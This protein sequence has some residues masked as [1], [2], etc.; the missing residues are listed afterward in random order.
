MRDP[1]PASVPPPDTAI[2]DDAP[3]RGVPVTPFAVATEEAVPATL[4]PPAA[5]LVHR[6]F[7]AYRARHPATPPGVLYADVSL[8]CY[9]GVVVHPPQALYTEGHPPPMGRT[10]PGG[11]P[12]VIPPAQQ[13]AAERAARAPRDADAHEAGTPPAGPLVPPSR[14]AVRPYAPADTRPLS[15]DGRAALVDAP[16]RGR[17]LPVIGFAGTRGSGKDAAALGCLGAPR[18]GGAR[19]LPPGWVP[20]ALADDLKRRVA[21]AFGVPWPNLTGPSRTREQPVPV[22]PDWRERWGV[23]FG[24]ALFAP[25]WSPGGAPYA[26]GSDLLRA[27]DVARANVW[28]CIEAELAA[29]DSGPGGTITARFLLQRVGTDFARRVHDGV[30]VDRLWATYAALCG[31]AGYRRTAGVIDAGPCYW[32][33]EAPVPPRP[34]TFLPLPHDGETALSLGGSPGSVCGSASPLPVGVL[35]TDARFPNE[36]RAVTRHGPPWVQPGSWRHGAVWWLDAEGAP[37]CPPRMDHA[38]E[39]EYGDLVHLV[40]GVIPNR[41]EDGDL[42]AFTRRVLGHVHGFLDTLPG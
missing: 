11:A 18:D 31:G 37:W 13:R 23:V 17:L 16:A 21:F 29:E 30:W 26:P 32:P 42:A 35:V 20:V 41:P 38:S 33:P 27:I 22:L 7:A 19:A 8:D 15:A 25:A 6:A 10:P 28:E 36:V 14:P 3:G 40:T 4:P 24:P 34:P 5:D 2:P 1:F 12:V 9:G 39:P